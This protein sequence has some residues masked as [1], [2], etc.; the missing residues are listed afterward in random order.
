MLTTNRSGPK[1]NQYSCSSYTLLSIRGLRLRFL[2]ITAEGSVHENA[3]CMTLHTVA[4]FLCIEYF[5]SV[6]FL[7]SA[8]VFNLWGI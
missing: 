2:K 8:V 1:N 3:R 4:C 7:F 5:Q 6:A